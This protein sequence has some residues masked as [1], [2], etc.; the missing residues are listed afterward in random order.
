M[1]L[2]GVDNS[3]IDRAMLLVCD[4]SGRVQA[5]AASAGQ[6]A[7]LPTDELLGRN[8]EQIF[9]LGSAMSTW[10][11]A[12]IHEAKNLDEYSAE[13]NIDN[14]SAKW[15]V[16]LQSL[17]RD[18]DLYGFALQIL[19]FDSAEE[20]CVL[21]AGDSIVARRQWHEIK[22]HIGALKLYATFLKRKLADGDERIT[23]EK[24]F[25]SVNALISYLDR[26]RRG[27]AH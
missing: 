15:F 7:Q 11:D 4:S 20:I 12:R 22:N 3:W 9:G 10:L 6:E 17:R 19:R 1:S 24:I 5:V 25:N 23:V 16:K 27:D 14:G 2:H 8:V 13:G 21:G 18:H 26:V